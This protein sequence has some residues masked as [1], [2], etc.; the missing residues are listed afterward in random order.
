M[1]AA[2]GP[3]DPSVME[4]LDEIARQTPN[5]RLMLS[6][7]QVLVQLEAPGDAPTAGPVEPAE[8]VRRIAD[9]YT[10]VAEESRQ[11]I[12]LV[13]RAHRFWHGLV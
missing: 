2:G 5:F 6:N 4:L 10:P 3:D 1:R 12:D 9:R 7:I 8:V 13:G 11:A